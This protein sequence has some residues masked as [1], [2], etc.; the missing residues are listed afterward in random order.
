MPEIVG[1]R[2]EVPVP[3]ETNESVGRGE[4]GNQRAQSDLLPASHHQTQSLRYTC[5]RMAAGAGLRSGTRIGHYEIVGSLGAGGM[6][7]VY[8]AR[9]ARLNRDAAIKILPDTF[10][11]DRDRVARFT[12][13]AQTLAAL[14][15]PNIAHVYGLED[16]PPAGS[17]A[18]DRDGP[19]D[20]FLKSVVDP[21]P[22]QSFYRSDVLFKNADGWSADDQ[23]IVLRS[24]AAKT[25][26]DIWLLPATGKDPATPLVI[27]PYRDHWGRPSPDSKWIAYVSEDSGRGELWVQPFPKSGKRTQVSSTGALMSWWAKDGRQLHFVSGDLSSL[28]AVDVTP[29]TTIG[30]GTPRRLAT[31]PPDIIA[32]DAMPDRQKFLV[33]VPQRTGAGSITI[34]RNWQP[35]K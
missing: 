3:E 26:Q 13:E 18:S 10:A 24:D 7:E 6:G 15:H 1:A 11:T 16:A 2:T 8:R 22:E 31:L 30:I 12:R 5:A 21:S 27:G 19:Q 32:I 4:R 25:Q 35:G 14:N 28:W 33:L 9:N 29:G 34:V 17:A 23:W 20:L